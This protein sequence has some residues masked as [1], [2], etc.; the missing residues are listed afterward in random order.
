V[1]GTSDPSPDPRVE[2]I[3]EIKARYEDELLAMANVIGVGVGLRRK[4]GV[5]SEEPVLVVLVSHKFP[6]AQ[7]AEKDLVPDRIEGVPVDVQEIGFIRSHD[8][9]GPALTPG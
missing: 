6:R 9:G 5:T 3:Q 4:G 8:A 1:S 7:L 2:R